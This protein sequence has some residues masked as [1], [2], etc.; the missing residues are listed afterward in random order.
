MQSL[1]I[2]SI[3]IWHIVI[4]LCNLLILYLV[5]KKFLYQPVKK[6][7]ESRQAAIDSRYRDADDAKSEALRSKAQ[8]EERMAAADEEA[9]GIVSRAVESANRQS[10][11]ILSDTREKADRMMSRARAEADAERRKAEDDIRDRVADVSAAIA[12][13]LLEREITAD[14]HSDL[15]DSFISEIGE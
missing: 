11:A 1:D 9:E 8:W 4:S 5:L 12:G 2:I 6:V 3:N 14:D 7:L 15:I 10:S 13:K